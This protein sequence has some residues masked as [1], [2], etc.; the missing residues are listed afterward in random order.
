MIGHLLLLLTQQLPLLPP[1]PTPRPRSLPSAVD[2][3]SRATDRWKGQHPGSMCEL[4]P[5]VPS[6]PGLS[7]PM[8]TMTGGSRVG[9]R[10]AWIVSKFLFGF[11][12]LLWAEQAPPGTTTLMVQHLDP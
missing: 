1:P 7:F 3:L 6:S 11:D 10:V 5:Y 9:S 4:R 8:D 12:G 2:M